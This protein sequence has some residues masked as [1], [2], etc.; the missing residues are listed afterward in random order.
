MKINV[1]I[2]TS[3]FLLG[4][5]FM[6]VSVIFTYYI[7][8][9]VDSKLCSLVRNMYVQNE[10]ISPHH[11]YQYFCNAILY[12]ISHNKQSPLKLFFHL[13]GNCE[14]LIFTT[15]SCNSL[16]LIILSCR[17]LIWKCNKCNES[18]I[19]GNFIALC[20][21]SLNKSSQILVFRF[22]F[23]NVLWEYSVLSL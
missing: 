13:L 18:V 7:V 8:I 6:E 10:Y 4:I 23:K 3:A 1:E 17:L 22:E 5:V 11:I 15:N 20:N 19:D 14:L 12:N 2:K 16:S 21:V 9:D